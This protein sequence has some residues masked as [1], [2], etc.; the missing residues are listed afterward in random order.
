MS[1][2]ASAE[3]VK[4]SVNPQIVM[5]KCSSQ[6]LLKLGIQFQCIEE[7]ENLEIEVETSSY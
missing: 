7:I 2:S 6:V 5:I 1:V 3:A 4:S